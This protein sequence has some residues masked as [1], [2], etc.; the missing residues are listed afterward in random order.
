MIKKISEAEAT[1]L[2]KGAEVFPVIIK[3]E[4]DTTES[5]V[6]LKKFPTGYVLGI[7]CDTKELFELYFS[8]D[9]E[10]IMGKCQQHLRI[11]QEKRHPFPQVD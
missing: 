3:E 8:E 5:A 9:Y 10:L 6:C 4:N 7:S 2:A 11:M 1:E